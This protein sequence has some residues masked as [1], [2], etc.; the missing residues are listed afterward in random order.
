[1]KIVAQNRGKQPSPTFILYST[2]RTQ[3][4]LVTF[5]RSR[6]TTPVEALEAVLRHHTPVASQALE[7]MWRTAL[8]EMTVLFE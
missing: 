8:E 6:V 3:G 7:T 1:M 2:V 5:R 4:N